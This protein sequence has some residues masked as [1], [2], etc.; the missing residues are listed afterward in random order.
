M[1]IASRRRIDLRGL[2]VVLGVAVFLLFALGH[3]LSG[4]LPRQEVCGNVGC[5]VSIY[6]MGL[7]P[8][9]VLILLAGVFAVLTTGVV[10]ALGLLWRAAR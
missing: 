10:L 4:G 3:I 7:V 5:E 9:P 1:R 6:W 2:S 8:P